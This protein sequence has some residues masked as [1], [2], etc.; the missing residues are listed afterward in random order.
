M[1]KIRVWFK[2]DG[3]VVFVEFEK[4]LPLSH[5]GKYV[6]PKVIKDQLRELGFYCKNVIFCRLADINAKRDE[7]FSFELPLKQNWLKRQTK[8]FSIRLADIAKVTT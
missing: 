8:R 7:F 2:I 1:E 3:S 5:L 6:L 4:R